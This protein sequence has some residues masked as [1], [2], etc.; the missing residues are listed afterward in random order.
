MFY[1]Q[2]SS[3]QSRGHRC[4]PFSPLLLPGTCLHF[5]SRMG[6]SIPTARRFSSKVVNSR[7]RAF[8]WSTL[9]QCKAPTG[10][11]EVRLEPTK[12]ILIGTWA[13]Y[14]AT[15][16][17]KGGLNVYFVNWTTGTVKG[18]AIW[19]EVYLT[20]WVT[21][22]L[23]LFTSRQLTLS[24]AAEPVWRAD[25]TITHPRTAVLLTCTQQQQQ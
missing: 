2:R 3:R 1:P 12:L 4:R 14:Q 15:G 25:S 11:H 7:S 19:F 13:A 6:F 10:M 23:A 21:S 17:S 20:A 22:R 5:L 9:V 24:S 8:R 18:R 16:D